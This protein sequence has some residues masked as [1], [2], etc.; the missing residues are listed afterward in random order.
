ME[1]IKEVDNKMVAEAEEGVLST[2]G[3]KA[4]IILA[5]NTCQNLYSEFSVLGLTGSC[6]LGPA[7]LLSLHLPPC[8]SNSSPLP[9][10][11]TR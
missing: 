4:N 9:I 6:V 1:L 3:K 8:V 11:G 10:L 5:L 7:S 2:G